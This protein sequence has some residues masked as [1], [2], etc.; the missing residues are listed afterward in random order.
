MEEPPSP[1]HEEQAATD[2]NEL[3]AALLGEERGQL[4]VA[5]AQGY[6]VVHDGRLPHGVTPLLHE[7]LEVLSLALSMAS[8]QH[9]PRETLSML[10]LAL[11]RLALRA[12]ASP[13]NTAAAGPPL[14]A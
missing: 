10:V 9:L 12:S 4:A 2:A 3:A 8:P 7:L 5:H 13:V 6:A 14:V 11:F 1:V